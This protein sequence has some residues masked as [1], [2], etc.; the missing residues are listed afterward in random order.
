MATGRRI[1]RAG[2]ARRRTSYARAGV[3][4]RLGEGGF[5]P[6]DPKHGN[7]DAYPWQAAID[8]LPTVE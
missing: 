4:V 8:A 7:F 6:H 1:L 2:A 5:S 3:T